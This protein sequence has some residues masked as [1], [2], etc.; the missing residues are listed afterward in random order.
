M[1]DGD[2]YFRKTDETLD[3]TK[4]VTAG[5]KDAVL[6]MCG[7]AHSCQAEVVLMVLSQALEQDLFAAFSFKSQAVLVI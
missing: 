3:L 4:K 7:T 2:V 1:P 5:V 6:R